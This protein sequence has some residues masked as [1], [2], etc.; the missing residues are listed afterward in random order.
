V[1][2]PFVL[3][4]VVRPQYALL[5]R[6]YEA[7]RANSLPC[8]RGVTNQ[9][10]VRM[11]IALGRAGF[12]LESFTPRARVHSGER[13]CNTGGMEHVLGA[14]ELANF[15]SSALGAPV[16]VRAQ[17]SGGGCAHA[18]GQI[19]GQTGILYF[20]NCFTRAG[21]SVQTGDHIDLFNGSQ[22]YNQIIHPRA[23]GNET[24]G[25]ELF[26]R[27]DQVWFWRIA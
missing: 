18:L 3:Q 22:Y 21:S 6:A 19:R 11:S 26:G 16:K 5:Q 23:G 15:L 8:Q 25:G 10:A 4:C 14:Q 1:Y 20:N 12:G 2:E 17:R 9:C 27:A 7:Y 13:G 24:T